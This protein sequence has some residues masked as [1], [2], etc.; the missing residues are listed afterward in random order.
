MMSD[1]WAA[2][3]SCGDGGDPRILQSAP[4]KHLMHCAN[5]CR[6]YDAVRPPCPDDGHEWEEHRTLQSSEN[7]LRKCRVCGA[8]G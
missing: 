3:P 4:P 7:V 1:E 6:R 8:R 5:C 2:C